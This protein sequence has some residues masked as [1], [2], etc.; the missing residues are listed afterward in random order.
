MTTLNL[1]FKQKIFLFA[2]LG[3]GCIC[4]KGYLNFHHSE[5]Q[6]EYLMWKHSLFTKLGFQCSIPRKKKNNTCNKNSYTFIC[7]GGEFGKSLRNLLY[8][9]NKDYFKSYILDNI[10]DLGL[11][12]W[13]MDDGCLRFIKDSEKN[14]KGNMLQLHICTDEIKAD[15]L[16]DFFKSQGFLFKKFRDHNHYS[17]YCSTRYSRK[18]LGRIERYIRRVPS[19]YYKVDRLKKLTIRSSTTISDMR[20]GVSAPIQETSFD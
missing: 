7:K 10:T 18:F 13:Y 3:D 4:K 11:A 17:I 15:F 14:I 8:T 1:T 19:M 6:R 9:P 2:A 5:D 16:I 20:V 12:L